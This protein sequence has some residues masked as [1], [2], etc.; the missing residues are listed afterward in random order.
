MEFLAL[1]KATI[2][3]QEAIQN[4]SIKTFVST[5]SDVNTP[6][7]MQDYIDTAFNNQQLANEINN[8]KTQFYLALHQDLVIGYLKVNFDGAQTES[9]YLNSLEIHR[10]YVLE[11]YHGKKVGQLLFD[12]AVTIAKENNLKQ[13]WL[14]VWEKNVKA[15]AF[16]TKNDFKKIAEHDF[17]L[18]NEK[19]T[20]YIMSLNL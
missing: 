14:G 3:D 5:F 10:I 18:G 9:G 1:K 15:I 16:Y 6:E 8:P 2:L 12:K 17:V 7:N 11:D 20:D 4:I 13:I 19:Q